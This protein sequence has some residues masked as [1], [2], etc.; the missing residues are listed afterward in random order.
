MSPPRPGSNSRLR[1]LL[2]ATGIIGVALLLRFTVF[3]PKPIPVRV[4]SVE[5]GRVEATVTNSKAGTLKSRRRSRLSAETGGRVTEILHREGAKVAAGDVIIRLEQAAHRARLELSESAVEASDAQHHEACLSR[6]HAKR[7]L[8]R[9]QSL[10]KQNVVS[11]DSLD[12]LEFTYQAGE[13]RCRAA[14]AE[15]SQAR[16]T[17]RAAQAE[18]DKTEIRAPFDGIIA[19]VAT[20]L[21][22]WVTPSPPLLTS[23]AVVDIIDPKALYVSAPMDEVDASRVRVGQTVKITIDSHRDQ[24][25]N[26]VVVRV[27]PYVLDLEAQNRTVAVEV[28]F[29]PPEQTNGM[30]PGTSADV[31]LILDVREQVLHIPSSALLEGNRVLLLSDGTLMD[32]D[33]ETGLRNWNVTEVRSGLN[34]G[35]HVV[36][37]LDRKEVQAG[38][39]AVIESDANSP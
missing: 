5:R 14:A 21:G 11:Q 12:R 16:A 32:R 26:G 33:V 17:L 30:L 7:E 2:I 19:E 22:E 38:A 23:P 31:E 29:A 15:Q 27:A 18:L 4:V 34:A 1:F 37:S 13:A 25:F 35:D 36:T 8:R 28:E 39:R 24:E 9:N 3:A 10:A 6:D 20:E